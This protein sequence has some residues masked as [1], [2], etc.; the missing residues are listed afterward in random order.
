MSRNF[1]HMCMPLTLKET[2]WNCRVG[3]DNGLL[4]EDLFP[5]SY[6]RFDFWIQVRKGDPRG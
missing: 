6:V 5:K 1:P 2:Y 4:N 3:I